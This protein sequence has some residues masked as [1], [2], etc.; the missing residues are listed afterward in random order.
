M[1]E[2]KI[3]KE[4]NGNYVGYRYPNEREITDKLNEIV[5]WINSKNDQLL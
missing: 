1:D 5:R 4:V 3:S 2:L